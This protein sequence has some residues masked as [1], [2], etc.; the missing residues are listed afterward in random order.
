VGLLGSNGSGKSSL[1]KTIYRVHKPDAGV[2]KL[3]GNDVWRLSVKELAQKNAVVAQENPTEFDF[4]V[5]VATLYRPAHGK[6]QGKQHMID[7]SIRYT[8][9]K[10]Y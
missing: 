4:K 7:G 8:C 2:I 10:S 6:G 9:A 1:R 5:D 3:A